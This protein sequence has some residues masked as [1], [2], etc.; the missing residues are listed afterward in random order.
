MEPLNTYF[1][2][3]MGCQM[4]EA[5]SRR[6]SGELEMLGLTRADA[7]ADA[8]VI[9]LNTCVVRQQAENKIYGRM[10][11]LK[12][13][14]AKNPDRIV[15]VM[16]CFVGVDDPSDLYRDYPFVDVFMPPSETGGLID[17]VTARVQDVADRAQRDQQLDS[18][19]QLPEPD[20]GTTVTANVS[21]ILGCS[22]R[23]SYCIIP[24]RR[25]NE[26]SRVPAEIVAEVTALT[27]QGVREVR[28]KG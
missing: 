24:L 20:R 13:L 21:I 5:D 19:F 8:D 11:S 18:P 12:P 1:V 22:H 27:E 25:G 3:T 15:S 28:A 2:W 14:K 26:V 10:G 16:G 23:C 9:V 6:L 17:L 7:A 4:N